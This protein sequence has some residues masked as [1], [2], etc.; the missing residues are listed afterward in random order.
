MKV[1]ISTQL[2]KE[3]AQYNDIDHGSGINA[4]G[5]ACRQDVFQALFSPPKHIAG[6]ATPLQPSALNTETISSSDYSMYLE[7]KI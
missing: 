1:F 7:P 3:Y 2:K 6:V 4:P 5:W